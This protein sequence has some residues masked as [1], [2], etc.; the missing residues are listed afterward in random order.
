MNDSKNFNFNDLSK[1]TPNRK[2]PSSKFGTP[3][4]YSNVSF[5]YSI[6]NESNAIKFEDITDINTLRNKFDFYEKSIKGVCYHYISLENFF[7]EG[8][9]EIKNKLVQYVQEFNDKCQK[10]LKQKAEQCLEAKRYSDEKNKLKENLNQKTED[11]NNLEKKYRQEK[12]ELKSSMSKEIQALK[13]K[14]KDA[15]DKNK[16]FKAK[17]EDY[18]NILKEK[19]K[20]ITTIREE[21][22]VSAGQSDYINISYYLG[23][24]AEDKLIQVNSPKKS[25]YNLF[26]SKFQK[27]E[28]NFNMYT[29]M[30]VDTSNKAREKFKEIYRK[31][32]GKEWIDLN[33]SIIKVHNFQTYN[34]NQ[35]LYWTNISNIHNTITA[36]IDEIC[37][38][39]NPT[40]NC[41]AKKL[42]EDSCDFLLNYIRGLKKLFFLQKEILDKDI[43]AGKV[44]NLRVGDYSQD[45]NKFFLNLKNTTNDIEDFFR[46]N[47]VVLS[48]QSYFDKFKEELSMEHTK[49]MMV[50]EYI[51]NIKSVFQQAKSIADKGENDFNNFKK[52]LNAKSKRNGIEDIEML[53]NNK[54]RNF[55]DNNN[56]N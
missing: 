41:D 7:N 23:D 26:N 43:G 8:S 38:L 35:D 46:E 11:Y 31:I 29:K 17:F 30:L 24:Q 53:S 27:A 37:E 3:L 45:K 40:K 20:A 22:A 47:N 13:F 56:I 50:D 16:K 54:S 6:E 51:K 32:K 49:N 10:F 18:E 33:N 14:L 15:E 48:N 21:F 1:H 12:E 39:V 2:I 52:D 36:I 4:D 28:N 34:I 25:D 9:I 42:N 5:P 55:D 19:D 44:E